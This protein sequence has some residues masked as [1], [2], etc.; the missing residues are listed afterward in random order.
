[1]QRF[2][3]TD[4]TVALKPLLD[5]LV[6]RPHKISGERYLKSIAI[7]AIAMSWVIGPEWFGGYS[8]AKV[9]LFLEVNCQN[10]AENAAKFSR[11]FGITNEFQDHDWR[12]SRSKRG[13]I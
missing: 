13:G 3:D 11:Q 12:K 7:R 1:L 6:R 8:L 2:Q 4:L 10:L 9:A 5:W